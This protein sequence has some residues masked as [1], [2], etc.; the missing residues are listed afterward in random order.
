[1]IILEKLSKIPKGI[2]YYIVII[3]MFVLMGNSNNRPEVFIEKIFKP[4]VGNGWIIH[5]A[6]LIAIVVIYNCLKQLNKI[7]ENYLIKTTFNRVILTIVLINIFSVVWIYCIQFYKG[8]FNDL[9]SIYLDRDKTSVQFSK[10]EDELSVSGTIDVVNCS[11]YIQKFHIKIKVPS[12]A[13]DDI[14]EEYFLLEKE[15]KVNPKEEKNLVIN[16]EI[17]S[18]IVTQ[19]SGY[20]SSAFEYILFNSKGEVVFK[21]ILDQYYFS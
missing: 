15:F 21:G 3:I 2:F 7:K 8:F 16:E 4:I 19:Y 6:G 12:L 11:N 20:N 5:Y 10:N 13:V 14:K 1:M 9:N 18:D 17:K